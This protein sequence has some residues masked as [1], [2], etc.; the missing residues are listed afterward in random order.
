[1]VIACYGNLVHALGSDQDIEIPHRLESVK[2]FPPV[3]ANPPHL[4][5]WIYAQAVGKVEANNPDRQRIF[6][7]MTTASGFGGP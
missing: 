1:M 3:G 5:G 4:Y 2:I 7:T 6:A